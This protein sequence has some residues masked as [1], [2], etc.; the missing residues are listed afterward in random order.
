MVSI[1]DRHSLFINSML[2]TFVA[3]NVFAARG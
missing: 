1:D 3:V 2:L